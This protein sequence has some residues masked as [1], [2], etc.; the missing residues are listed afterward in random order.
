MRLG[1]N[2]LYLC[3]FYHSA[4]IFRDAMDSLE[5]RGYKISAFNAVSKGTVIDEKYKEIMDEK[6]I[7]KEC[8]DSFD[9][10]MYFLKQTKILR[11]IKQN[12]RLRE[13]DLIHSH[14][15]FNGGWVSRE[16]KKEYGIPYVVT[17]R[18]TDLND[19]LKIPFFNYIGEKIIKD[20]SAVLFLSN[21]YKESYRELFVK[22]NY[23]D[24]D[25]KSY[26]IPNGIEEF[27]L[28]N[29]NK[30]K[31]QVHN[32]LEI[33][34][35]GKIDKNK[36]I[37]KIVDSIKI[38]RLMGYEAHLTVI[39]KIMD[40]LIY[41]K[42]KKIPFVSIL[43]YMNKEELINYYRESDIFVMPSYRESF[44]R[45]YVEA[46]S[47]GTPIVY[48][49]GQGFDGFFENGVLGY[50][51]NPYSAMEIAW[52]II[53]IRNQYAKLSRQ[54]IDNCTQFSW[55]CIAEKLDDFYI[56]AVNYKGI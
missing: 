40:H 50:K 32:P 44:G 17:V 38:L 36:N 30:V 3:T 34:Y 41:E 39:G 51:V 5:K 52:S 15:M 31:T 45:V 25:M 55:E 6:V 16:I 2:I 27:W 33:L 1:M 7:H 54:S 4:F 8:F 10:Y 21:S 19:F 22:K 20:A 11:A 12:V 37:E 43:P 28:A 23:K 46:I 56:K 18:N 13:Y 53:R 49:E 24:F 9:R 42:I 29:V 14:T 26:V 35:V 47:Q 48:T